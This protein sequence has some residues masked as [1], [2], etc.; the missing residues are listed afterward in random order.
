M[1]R[2]SP[3]PLATKHKILSVLAKSAPVV[4]IR[5]GMTTI[6]IERVH[7]LKGAI[8]LQLKIRRCHSE[9]ATANTFAYRPEAEGRW[10]LPQHEFGARC[11]CLVGLL[12]YQHHRS[13]PEIHEQLQQRTVGI[14]PR[15]VSN[16]LARYDELLA[17]KL[18]DSKRLKEI[19]NQ[20]QHVILAID[21]LQPDMGQEVLWVILDCLSGEILLAQTLLSAATE[22]LAALLKTSQ[23]GIKCPRC[24][25][26]SDGQQS[27][28]KAVAQALQVAH[29][30]CHFHYLR[31][32]NMLIYEA[33]RHAKRN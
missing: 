32:A 5:C 20:Q 18:G 25:V 33:D 3:Q 27:I 14:S 9:I 21:G 17:V 7:T 15:T 30:L 26:I 10:A 13:V 12:R 2:R 28:R 11:D 16:L 1:V 22:D 31:E 29:G 23:T 4:A 6:T 19:L 24:R 8:Q